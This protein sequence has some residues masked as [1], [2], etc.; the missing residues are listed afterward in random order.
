LACLAP[1]LGCAKPSPKKPRARVE[2]VVGRPQRAF[3]YSGAELLT[4]LR[5]A[6]L[7]W[8]TTCTE[9]SLPELTFRLGAEREPVARDARNVIRVVTGRFC[10]DGARDSMDCYEP[11]R[12]AITHIY[13]PLDGS[14]FDFVAHLPEM[15]IELNGADFRWRT[16]GGEMLRETLLHELGHVLGLQHS[17]EEPT[18]NDLARRTL[19]YPYPL[20]AG[21][22]RLSRPSAEDCRALLTVA[23]K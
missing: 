5:E 17:C 9:A 11:R 14:T 18:C 13:P 1:I 15:D 3:G 2:F 19:M 8:R 6:D 7:T 21:R 12:A 10:P 20:E 23:R 4:Q 16:L 22:G